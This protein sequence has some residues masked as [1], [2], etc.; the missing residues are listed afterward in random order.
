[1]SDQ[2]P[3]FRV[4]GQSLRGES[5]QVDVDCASEAVARSVA[6]EQG[7][8]NTQTVE[9]VERDQATNLG[10]LTPHPMERVSL[11]RIGPGFVLKVAAGVFLGLLAWTLA[12]FLFAA[13][14]GS[15][16]Y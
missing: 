16:S 5:A 14:L 4:H 13:I 2:G 1:M 10:H 9:M 8:V 7:L 6:I 12:S 11:V 15:F 3:I